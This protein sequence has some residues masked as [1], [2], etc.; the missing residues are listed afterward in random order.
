MSDDGDIFDPDLLYQYA[1]L[2]ND[3]V[4]SG[5]PL[6]LQSSITNEEEVCLNCITLDALPS[7]RSIRVRYRPDESSPWVDAQLTDED[8]NIVFELVKPVPEIKAGK[9]HE[10]TDGFVFLSPGVYQ[11]YLKAD[12]SDMVSERNEE[13]NDANSP[14]GDIRG[15]SASGNFRL[16]V[17]VF[18]PTGKIP[19]VY[20]DKPVVVQYLEYE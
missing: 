4:N 15:S 5:A 18:D 14:E 1:N 8:G 7:D 3:V 12:R 17:R 11:Y 13:N 19:P 2:E 9:K 20:G 16:S 10:K 6:I